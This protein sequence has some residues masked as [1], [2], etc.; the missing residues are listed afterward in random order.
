VP[1][2]F[3]VFFILSPSFFDLPPLQ[4]GERGALVSNDLF[5][6]GKGEGKIPITHCS[7]TQ[8]SLYSAK[9]LGVPGPKNKKPRSNNVATPG[10]K[11]QKDAYKMVFWQFVV[12]AGLA[13]SLLVLKG[14]Q[15][16]VSVLL[17][18]LAYVLPNLMFVWRVFARTSAAEAQRFMIAFVVG[19][20]TKLTLSAV[21]FVMTVKYLPVTL[22][23]TLGGYIAAIVAFWLVS[24]VI[25]SQELKGEGQ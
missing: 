7:A 18:G 21:L 8:K 14:V 23:P 5:N 13:L 11:V 12:I 3:F 2:F 9:F 10:N 19:E 15:S 24:F 6:C 17:G 20:A 22:L 4:Q 25:M 1:L 16:G